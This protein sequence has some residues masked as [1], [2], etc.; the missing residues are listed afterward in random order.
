MI[1]WHRL[2]LRDS[3]PGRLTEKIIAARVTALTR[4]YNRSLIALKR[5][6]ARNNYANI[7]F[8]FFFV[9][10]VVL[11]FFFFLETILL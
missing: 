7:L 9:V 4:R 1:P 5:F 6:A 10:V 3:P 8:F 2:W 11:L